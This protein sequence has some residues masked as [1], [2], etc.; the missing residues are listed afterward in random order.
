MKNII[1][2]VVLITSLLVAKEGVEQNNKSIK[3]VA[4]KRESPADKIAAKQ[5][6]KKGFLTTQF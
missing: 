3:T 2:I 1:S 5:F 6:K 4:P